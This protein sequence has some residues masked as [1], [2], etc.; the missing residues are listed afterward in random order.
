MCDRGVLDFVVWISTTLDYPRFLST[1]IGRFLLSLA[2]G[3]RIVYLYADPQILLSRSD[4]PRDFL[5]RELAYYTVLSKYYAKM[6]IDT[7]KNNPSRVAAL[8]F[9]RIQGEIC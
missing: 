1:L 4:V 2:L 7:G 8:V 5:L 9:K 6:Y 3:E